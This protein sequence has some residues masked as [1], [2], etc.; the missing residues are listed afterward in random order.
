MNTDRVVSEKFSGR[1]GLILLIF[2]KEG[3]MPIDPVHR[4]IEDGDWYFWNEVW[5]DEIGPFGTEEEC[6][7]ALTK[8]CHQ[9]L[10]HA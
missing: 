5:A 7:E 4:N 3:V 9:I 2:N 8:Y 10:G 1:L 6:R